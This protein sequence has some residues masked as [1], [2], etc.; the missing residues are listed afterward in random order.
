MLIFTISLIMPAYSQTHS[1]ENCETI[2]S[3]Y[4]NYCINCNPG[5]IRNELY[6]CIK[7]SNL[8]T[9]IRSLIENC[10]DYSNDLDC[11][12]CLEG[13]NIHK[14]RC[15]PICENNCQCFEPNDCLTMHGRKLECKN[16]HCQL[17]CSYDYTQCCHCDNGYGL[18]NLGNCISCSDIHCKLC[19]K[20]YRKCDTCNDYYDNYGNCCKVAKCKDCSDNADSCTTCAYSYTNYG[21]CCPEHCNSCYIDSTCSECESGYGLYAGVCIKCLNNCLSCTNNNCNSCRNWI[22][23]DDK[24]ACESN[25]THTPNN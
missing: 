14:G 9:E 8:N 23:I 4:S 21:N 16:N 13:Y 12:K 1:L 25:S 5:Y 20:D 19:N 2:D 24:G 7:I 22:F 11:K 10:Q 6:G 3:R 18:D 17:C 15:E